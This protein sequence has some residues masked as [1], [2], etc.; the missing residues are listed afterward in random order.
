VSDVGAAILFS[1]DGTARTWANN[2]KQVNVETAPSLTYV[3]SGN[4]KV[5]LLKV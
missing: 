2:P 1:E 4:S 3:A 5:A